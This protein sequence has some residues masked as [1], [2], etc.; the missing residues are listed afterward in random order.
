MRT[1]N[2]TRRMVWTAL[3]SAVAAV[4]MYLDMAL[5]IFPGFLKMDLSDLPA[6]VAAFAWGPAAGVLTELIKNLIHSLVSSTAWI[7][8]LANFLVGSALVAPAG[9]IYRRR[10]TPGGAITALTSATLIATAVAA[11]ANY[12]L[13][14]PFY[15]TLV[16]LD[17]IIAMS[18]AV[19][20]A[21]HD[22]AS[23]VVYGVVPFNL[24][25]GAI[26]SLAAL[27]LFRRIGPLLK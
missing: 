20:P 17:K 27:Y 2:R 26:V 18:A 8:E 12:Y 5:P 16:P 4:L 9:F 19:V 24:F 25:K 15:S 22:R 3:L 1:I 11:L 6:L 23:L 14:L 10:Q 7:G 13:L 21:I